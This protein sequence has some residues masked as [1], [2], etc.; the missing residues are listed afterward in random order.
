MKVPGATKCCTLARHSS[1]GIKTLDNSTHA[2]VVVS[3]KN[4]AG[5][6]LEEATKAG[7]NVKYNEKL[8]DIDFQEKV[9]IFEK[10]DDSTVNMPYSLLVACDGSK[11]LVRTL[12]ALKHSDTFQVRTE[13]DTMEYQVAVLTNRFQDI[14][15]NKDEAASIPVET[16]HSWNDRPANS[17]CL[18]FPHEEGG[19]LFVVI[20]PGGKLT[21]FKE[22]DSYSEALKSLLPDIVE[23]ARNE[24]IQQLKQSE[25]STGGTCVWP[26]FLGSPSHSVVLVGDSGHGMFPS[27]GQGANCALESAAVFCNTLSDVSLNL[28][29]WSEHVVKEYNS[30]RFE[31]ATA[32]V[33]LTY[34]GMGG[35][36]ARHANNASLLFMLQVGLMML[37]NKI[38]FGLVPK[39]AILRLMM[40]EDES[41]SSLASQHLIYERQKLLLLGLAIV[42][43]F[44]PYICSKL[45]DI[46]MMLFG[47]EQQEL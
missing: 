12:L 33:T 16:V 43:P 17:L 13:E 19:M 32:A 37:L 44:A 2:S 3:R 40:G 24:I 1:K 21:E 18:G 34:N 38:T 9:A 47:K 42:L 11:S 41:Y 45:H 7:V 28:E 39:P 29:K 14:A 30:R 20:F 6:L 27:L 46:H 25:P 8:V 35:N 4:L 23:E 5:C 31:D 22:N 10:A 26:S 15:V 36:K